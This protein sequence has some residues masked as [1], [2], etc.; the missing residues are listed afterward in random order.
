[1]EE[2]SHA[3]VCISDTPGNNNLSVELWI[4][5]SG[6]NNQGNILFPFCRINQ[7][8]MDL[9]YGKEV[10]TKNSLVRK[11]VV[12]VTVFFTG[13]RVKYQNYLVIRAARNST[14]YVW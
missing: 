3:V 9:S 12:Y 7:Y 6:L 10:W 8:T 5:I 4:C 2:L 14:L 1:M 11:S 13:I